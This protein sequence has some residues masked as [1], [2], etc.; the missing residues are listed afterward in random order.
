[1]S[2]IEVKDIDAPGGE[3]VLTLGGTNSNTV[4]VGKST[5]TTNVKGGTI[6]LG[7]SGTNLVIP[8]GATITNN[9]T[10]SGFGES[11]T[12]ALFLEYKSNTSYYTG[13]D[14][15]WWKC[16]LGTSAPGHSTIEADVASGFD[17]ANSR[18]VCPVGYAGWYEIGGWMGWNDNGQG[19]GEV[20]SGY[21]KNGTLHR[22]HQHYGISNGQFTQ[23]FPSI[24]IDLAEGDYIEW[25][26]HINWTS[27]S[28]RRVTN[29]GKWGYRLGE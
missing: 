24:I 15:T 21:Y 22:E 23:A 8:S 5:S 7:A 28:A 29:W 16:P 14:N 27:S 6:N 1:M 20:K 25:Y 2:K 10:Q 13:V 18:W 9:G 4:N 19:M 17:Q 26:F 12:D 3:S 11:N